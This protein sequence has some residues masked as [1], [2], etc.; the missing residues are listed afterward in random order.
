MTPSLKL[1]DR[2]GNVVA[3]EVAING[4]GEFAIQLA[5]FQQSTEYLI[6]V[7][8]DSL[9]A[10]RDGNYELVISHSSEPLAFRELAVGQFD[11][12][13]K[14]Y[15]SLH[16]ARA[17]MFQF[18]LE[19]SASTGSGNAGVWASIYDQ[20]GNVVYQVTARSGERRTSNT[21]ML[22]PGSY[23]I[24]IE[25][26][27]GSVFSNL[28]YRLIGI[29]VGDPQGP[30]FTDPS[31]SPFDQDDDGDFVFPDDVVV[32][33]NFVVV[34]GISSNQG[35]PPN[36]NPPTNLFNWYWGVFG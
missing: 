33:E 23:T 2:S 17:Q 29:D 11:S 36:D 13:Q 3:T 6:A 35:N 16:V 30:E 9:L 25:K 22:L 15:H 5:N 12:T 27:A 1:M 4:N 31:D 8:S 14:K 28:G 10:F 19:A 18:G 26:A 24:E 32:K 7:E 34:D 20:N 21:V